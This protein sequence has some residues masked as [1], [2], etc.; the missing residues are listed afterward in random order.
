LGL[1]FAGAAG[2]DSQPQAGGENPASGTSP[3]RPT[4]FRADHIQTNKAI[5]IVSFNYS[6]DKVSGFTRIPLGAIT[7]L[8]R[9]AYILSALQEAG[10]DPLENH[11]FVIRFSTHEESTR[12]SSYSIRNT[13]RDSETALPAT[14]LTETTPS[15]PDGA[16][17]FYAFKVLPLEPGVEEDEDDDDESV[18]T[19]TGAV[20]NCKDVADKIVRRIGAQCKRVGDGVEVEEK[21]VVR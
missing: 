19:G 21:D 12:Y 3:A 13:R 7:A 10:R 2:R 6:L 18:G 9:G 8:Q 1:A 16:E 5:Y 20:G 14:P 15:E 4:R 11:G 17:E